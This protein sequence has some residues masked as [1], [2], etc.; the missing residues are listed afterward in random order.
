MKAE[1]K[2]VTITTDGGCNP[3]PGQGA[4]AAILRYGNACKT[5]SGASAE[6]TTNNRMELTAI[7]EALEA[8]REPCVVTLRTDSQQ[9]IFAVCAG[10]LAPGSRRRQKWERSGKNMDLVR[11][12][13]A[14]LDRHVVHP[15]W[16]KGHAGDHDNEKC[17]AEC[18]RRIREAG[19]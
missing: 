16:V 19:A 10:Y 12:I 14:Q 9:A 4:W 15:K 1:K 2:R 8:L 17:D 13:W 6:R 7:A 5:I 11:R 3:N 18:S